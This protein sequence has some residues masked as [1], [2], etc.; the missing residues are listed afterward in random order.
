MNARGQAGYENVCQW[1]LPRHE[2]TYAP[3]RPCE[4]ENSDIECYTVF[5][6]PQGYYRVMN[7]GWDGHRRVYI[8]LTSIC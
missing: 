3:T 8:L 4:T 1:Y 6:E 2:A 5:D 7:V